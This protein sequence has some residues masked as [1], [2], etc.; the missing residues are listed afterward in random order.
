MKLFRS[1][2]ISGCLRA[3]TLRVIGNVLSARNETGT[4]IQKHE[5]GTRFHHITRFFIT[6]CFRVGFC[7]FEGKFNVLSC[8]PR[9]PVV[10]HGTCTDL[11]N[12]LYVRI[13]TSSKWEALRA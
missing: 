1:R 7:Q 5:Y 10:T 2:S 13:Q 4:F 9:Q 3:T 11:V 6:E 12:L 8:A